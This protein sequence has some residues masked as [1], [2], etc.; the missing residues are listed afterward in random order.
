MKILGISC[1]Y[2]DSAASIIVDNI[3]VASV[4]EERFTRE[5]H[6]P[7]FPTNSINF[8]LEYTGLKIEE[9]DAVVFYDKPVVKFERL[10]S[11]FYEVAPKGLIPFIKSMPLGLKEKLFLTTSNAGNIIVEINGE[12]R[13]KIGKL[14]EIKDSFFIDNK[15]SN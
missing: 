7:N 8:C 6:T 14:G 5:K 15:F 4:Q 13:G 3:I 1:Y 2:H 11:T 12:I 10:L 9:L